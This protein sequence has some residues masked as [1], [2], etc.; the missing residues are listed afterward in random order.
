MKQHRIVLA[1]VSTSLILAACNAPSPTA[2]PSPQ[3]TVGVTFVPAGTRAVEQAAPSPTPRPLGA[4]VLVD[5][6]PV[7]G[8]AL[9]IDKP[10]QFVFDQSMDRPSVEKSIRVSAADGA[11]VAGAFEW[12]ADNVVRFTPAKAWDRAARYDIEIKGDARSSKGLALAR[13]ASFEVSTIGRLTV[14]QTI[15]ADGAQDVNPNN[16]ITVLFNRPVVSVTAL[17]QQADLPKPLVLQPEVPGTGQWLNTS[18]YLFK[19]TKA[20]AAGVTYRGIVA[21]GLRDTT[22]ALLDADASFVFTVAPPV[23]RAAFPGPGAAGIDLRQPVRVVFSQKMDRASAESSFTIEPAIAGAFKWGDD[24]AQPVEEP[25]P[26]PANSSSVGRP[27]ST[28]DATDV[29]RFVPSALFARD[30]V[31][32]ITL[33]AGARADNGAT[34][35]AEFRSSF[36]T[37]P[38]PSV[39]STEPENGKSDAETGGFSIRFSAP[40]SAAT[41]LP[42]LTFQPAISLSDVYSYY[43]PYSNQFN[44][45]V[46]LKPSTVYRVRIGADVKDD[47]G[48]AI[49][50]PGDVRFTTRALQP[51][52]AFQSAGLAGTYN[53]A[54]ADRVFASYRNVTD[55]NLELARLTPEQFY[56]F[57]GAQNSYDNLRTFVAKSDQILR[58]WKITSKAS[59]NETALDKIVFNADGSSLAPGIYMLTAKADEVTALDPEAPPTRQL[60]VVTNRHVALKRAEKHAL[61]WVTDLNSGRPVPNARVK[62]YGRKFAELGAGVT[63]AAG[64]TF[65][66]ALIDL[67]ANSLPFD[68]LFVMVD[69]DDKGAPGLG[70]GAVWSDA[71]QGIGPY[72]FNLPTRYSV[73]PYFAYLYTERPIYRPGQMVFFKGVVR[74]E[75]DARYSVDDSINAQKPL[76]TIS[77]PQGQQVLSQS[78]TLNANGTFNGEFA[79]DN[80][81]SSGNYYLQLC[82]PNSPAMRQATQS[83]CSYTG[84]NFL[85]SSYRRP[86]FDVS[87]SVD[88]AD[89]LDGETL[90]ATVTAKY[91]FG[92]NMANAKVR[93]SLIASDWIFDR[94]NGPGNYSFG[95]YDYGVRKFGFGESVATGDGVTGPDGTLV[96]NVPADVSKRKGSARFALEMS[97][98]DAN[99]Q[100]VSARAGAIVHKGAFYMGVAPQNYVGLVGEAQSVDVISVDWTGKPIGDKAGEVKFYRREWFSTQREDAG[101]YREYT[102]VPSDTLVS[103]SSITTDA[104]GKA[105]ASFTPENGGEYRIVVEGLGAALSANSLYVSSASEYVS[106]RVEN[107]DRIE[108]KSDKPLYQVGETAKI[109]V[110]SP[111]QGAVQALLTIERGNIIER[112]NIVLNNNSTVLE[113][114]VDER[115][116]PNVYVSVLLVKGVDAN[117]PAAAFKLGYAQFKVDPRAFALNVQI[118]PDKPQYGPR[119]TATYDIVVTDAA[120]N[121]VQAELSVALVDKAVLSLTEPNSGKLLDSFYGLRQLSV[122]SADSLSV[123]V[124]R[125]NLAAEK[126]LQGK[127]GGG[128]GGD[129]ADGIFTRQNFKDTA[130]WS[131]VLQTDAQGK[132]R[133]QI[134]LPDNLTTWVMDARAVTTDTHVGEGVN[135]VISTK[136]LLIRPVTPRF[137]VAGDSVTLGAVVNNTGETALDTEVLLEASGIV[138]KGDALQRVNVPAK[139]ST[140]LNWNVTVVD[141]PVALMTFT[142]K[143]GTLQDSSTPTLATAPGGG[144]PILNYVAPETIATAGDVGEAGAKLELI[145]LPSR[146]DTGRGSLHVRVDASLGQADLRA[147]RA[148]DA[149]PYESN[150]WAASRLLTQLALRNVLTQST[151]ADD[152]PIQRALQSFFNSQYSEGGWG[153]WSSDSVNPYLTAHIVL[154]IARAKEAGFVY[155]QS[156]LDRAREYLLLSTQT[157]AAELATTGAAN[158]RAFILFA[159]GE[160]GYP[161]A[162]RLGALFESREK[163]GHYGKALLSMAMEKAQP[164]DV[165]VKTLLADVISAAL[166]SATGTHWQ[167]PER[168]F[169]NFFGNTRSTSIALMML[170]RL[171]AKNAFAPNAVR[172]LMVARAGDWWE[173]SHET[174]WAT[175]ALSEWLA[176]SGEKDARFSWRA[177]LNDQALL[178]GN[179]QSPGDE[180]SVEVARLLRGQVN[181]LVFERGEALAGSGAQGRMYYTARLKIYLP[182]EEAKA[183]DRGIII[184]R[185]YE[186]GDCAPKPEKP[187]EA[188]TAAKIGETVRVRLTVMAPNDLNYVRINDPLPGGAEAIDTS[189]K[190]SQTQ[191]DNGVQAD[192]GGYGGWGWWWFSNTDIRD[193]SVA[194]FASY[195]PAGTYEY[196]Y[197][198]RPSI[199]GEFKVMP[200]AIE[201]QYFPEVFGRSDGAKFVINP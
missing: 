64:D 111:F 38:V 82:I 173:S 60:M 45:N 5:R 49:D 52:V 199:A 151:Q 158:R 171:D 169:D 25:R 68:P 71:S 143:S 9:E 102:S 197:T 91:F 42:N 183:I 75:D 146:L 40:V 92:G 53:A 35:A 101:G 13:P 44:L 87:V 95:D 27:P 159:L 11:S 157:P 43:E 7:R 83:D 172:W 84:I 192:F 79:L 105:T 3:P 127:G 19:P 155:D 144:I 33:K 117:N 188:I 56:A 120:G 135:E 128:G 112:R 108:L 138:F 65:G 20:L 15:P 81:A 179:E 174:A 28:G 180:I 175:M 125:L 97:V 122:R 124:D 24:V 168:D 62:I 80:A 187:C 14:A 133:V 147:G 22:G 186:R 182:V 113:I 88:K 54:K 194:V 110:P 189:L 55:V 185:K 149:Y 119:D 85:V 137:F 6:A 23:V 126:S 26:E 36:R 196:V 89:Y 78:V 29:M 98:T 50:N 4:P 107:S 46:T 165:R 200:A 17:S 104:D 2:T 99:D 47:Y 141:A 164:G 37:I 48:V 191:V 195:L 201:E 167:E 31:Y 100:S 70:F 150:E 32:T 153:W 160:A 18:I 8:E 154:A 132:A 193:D 121:P 148:L 51:F 118:T 190:T 61:V 140:R 86:E 103:T 162:G 39:V 161:D 145:A 177:A 77:S 131:A 178:Q 115:F 142:V 41:I 58:A 94:Y 163:L 69:T 73:E 170:A 134:P 109:L 184:A 1:V 10:V 198:M 76:I 123:N 166:S 74:R 152:A 136:P 57:V 67:P 66:Q 129:S 96:V 90:K 116:A 21:A 34:T 156:S 139:S 176:R 12:T 16:T 130:H 59:L 181:Q 72:D 114:P 106:W 63:E 93:W 30:T